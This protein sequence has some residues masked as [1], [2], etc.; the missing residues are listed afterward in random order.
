MCE[1]PLDWEQC[2]SLA[3]CLPSVSTMQA[4]KNPDFLLKS[5][6]NEHT[7][8]NLKTE[9]AYVFRKSLLILLQVDSPWKTFCRFKLGMDEANMSSMVYGLHEK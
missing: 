5:K 8:N 6:R 7:A 4:F 9:C 3:V 2:L 1:L